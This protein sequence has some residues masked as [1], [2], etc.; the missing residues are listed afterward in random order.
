M[1]TLP[2]DM[3]LRERE[4]DLPCKGNALPRRDPGNFVAFFEHR[5]IGSDLLFHRRTGMSRNQVYA[6]HDIR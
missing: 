6:D 5:A 1:A 4:L 2:D 3:G